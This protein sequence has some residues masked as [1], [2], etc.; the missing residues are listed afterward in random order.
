MLVSVDDSTQ[1]RDRAG[2]LRIVGFA[3]KKTADRFPDPPLSSHVEKI[4]ND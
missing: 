2:Q 3:K 4:R 1:R